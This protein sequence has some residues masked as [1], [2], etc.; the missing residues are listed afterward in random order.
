MCEQRRRQWV[1][2]V[3]GVLFRAFALSVGIR[4]PAENGNGAVLLTFEER[5]AGRK[6]SGRDGGVEM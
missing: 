5:G 4:A 3:V 2:A 1:D 6:E